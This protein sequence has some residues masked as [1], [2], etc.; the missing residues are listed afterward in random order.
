[1]KRNRCCTVTALMV[2]DPR[3]AAGLAVVAFFGPV[4]NAPKKNVHLKIEHVRVHMCTRVQSRVYGCMDVCIESTCMCLNHHETDKRDGTSIPTSASAASFLRHRQIRQR[5]SLIAKG[6][7]A[8][9][10]HVVSPDRRG[11]AGVVADAADLRDGFDLWHRTHCRRFLAV[12]WVLR[13]APSSSSNGRELDNGVQRNFNTHRL[14]HRRVAK[15]RNE[16]LQ[17]A[18]M[19]DHQRWCHLLLDLHNHGLQSL[20]EISV[21]FAARKSTK[22]PRQRWHR[23]VHLCEG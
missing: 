15:V 9:A 7:C 8:Q 17:H 18:H 20:N 22:M 19:A 11:D 6:G 5:H 21:R 2:D 14:V 12:Q 1:M 10:P 23:T 13:L 4:L 3:A 16:H